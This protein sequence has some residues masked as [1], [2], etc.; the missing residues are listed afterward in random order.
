LSIFYPLP[1]LPLPVLGYDIWCKFVT[2]LGDNL[3]MKRA[4]LV[5]IPLLVVLTLTLS[6]CG[7][8][9]YSRSYTASGDGTNPNS[10]VENNGQ[11]LVTDDLN[12][13]V[14]L[15][16]HSDDVEVEARFFGPENVP[17]GDPLKTTASKDV[18][19]VLLGLDFETRPDTTTDWPRG[20]YK[21]EVYVDGERVETINFEVG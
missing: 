9:V 17:V 18:G 19:T 8:E 7:G 13:V 10:L 12:V 5:L 20:A 1:L 4:H 6:A 15:N 2:F 16:T 21:V 14:K 11:F 3:L